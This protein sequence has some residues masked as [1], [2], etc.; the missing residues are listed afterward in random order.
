MLHIILKNV[1]FNLPDSYDLVAGTRVENIHLYYDIIKVTAIAN[2]NQITMVMDVPL[3]TANRHFVLYRIFTLPTRVANGT[4]IQYLPEFLYIGIN[5]IQ[6]NYVLYTEAELNHCTKG[7][8]TVCPADKAIYSTCVVTCAS[9]L[10]FQLP[11]SH[12]SCPRKVLLNPQTPLLHHYESIWIYHL[13]EVQHVTLCCWNNPWTSTTTTL[14]VN[15]IILN[16]SR[17]L[18]TA[19]KFQ[20]LPELL[21]NAQ[22]TL[23]NTSPYVPNHAAAI[24]KQELRTLQA[25]IPPEVEQLE[26][27]QSRMATPHQ[28]I[29]LD[30]FLHTSRALNRHEYRINWY[31]TALAIP[32]ALSILTILSYIKKS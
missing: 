8:I 6:H 1:S 25:A 23:H 21:G 2:A 16:A 10:F 32:C 28:T 31:L 29:D 3:K 13:P 7:I 14:E 19:N 11:D 9:S 27:V 26:Y 18:L 30:S 24:S 4:F 15:G 5:D 12:I 22:A 20:M 17:C